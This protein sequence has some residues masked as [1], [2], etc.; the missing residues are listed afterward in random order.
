MKSMYWNLK[1]GKRPKSAFLARFDEG[2]KNKVIATLVGQYVT[3]VPAR[4]Q[5]GDFML[6]REK[7]VKYC[8]F[9]TCG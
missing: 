9:F 5:G 7:Y 2:I 1:S 3:D 4:I 8:S 6:A